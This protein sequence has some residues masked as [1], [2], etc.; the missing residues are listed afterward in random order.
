MFIV[1]STTNFTQNAANVIF[2]IQ[3]SSFNFA[4]LIVLD[5]QAVIMCIIIRSLN[6][7][8]CFDL[9]RNSREQWVHQF[10]AL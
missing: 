1:I 2:M 4:N 5:H 7:S 6:I 10:V 9:Y 3:L 8:N